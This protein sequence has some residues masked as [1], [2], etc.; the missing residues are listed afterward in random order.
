M[1]FSFS[2]IG[3]WWWDTGHT[4]K[5]RSASKSIIVPVEG[6]KAYLWS[7]SSY[8]IVT[9]FWNS[10]K[11]RRARTETW[12]VDETDNLIT[13]NARHVCADIHTTR[14][15]LDISHLTYRVKVTRC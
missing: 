1:A 13:P 7:D 15:R 3:Q 14:I 6:A 8:T 11:R 2:T 10:E 9:D 5:K 4:P 12:L